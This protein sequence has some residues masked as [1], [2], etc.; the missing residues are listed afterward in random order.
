MHL[1][2]LLLIHLDVEDYVVF[3]AQVLTL[4]DIYLRILESLVLV[5]FLCQGLGTRNHVGSDL[6]TLQQTQFL[7]QIL[8]LRLLLDADVV[9]VAHARARF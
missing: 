8:T 3:L 9:D 7:L 1:G 4:G 2:L 5:V 6:R